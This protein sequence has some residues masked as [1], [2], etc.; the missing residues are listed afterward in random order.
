[1]FKSFSLKDPATLTPADSK[2]KEN[3]S[4][5][6]EPNSKPTDK[7]EENKLN[8]AQPNKKEPNNVVMQPLQPRWA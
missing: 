8:A 3:K 7:K 2:P 4:N 5:A 6:A 1:M